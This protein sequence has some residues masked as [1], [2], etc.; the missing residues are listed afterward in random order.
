MHS[1]GGAQA[2]RGNA[3]TGTRWHDESVTRTRI[4]LVLND[5]QLEAND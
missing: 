4:Q 3:I 2:H 1:G 5:A